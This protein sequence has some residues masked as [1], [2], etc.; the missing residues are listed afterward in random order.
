M[1][2]LDLTDTE[3]DQL[4]ELGHISVLICTLSP[5]WFKKTGVLFYASPTFAVDRAVLTDDAFAARRLFD[6]QV[7]F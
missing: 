2:Y 7:N 5:A 3:L 6:Q 1:A 4:R